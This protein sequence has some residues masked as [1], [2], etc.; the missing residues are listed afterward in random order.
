MEVM[1]LGARMANEGG[2]GRGRKLARC[3][4]TRTRTRSTSIRPL[5]SIYNM[6][7]SGDASLR[8]AICEQSGEWARC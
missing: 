4:G 1:A 2:G 5:Y 3:Y 7:V 8:G 6:H